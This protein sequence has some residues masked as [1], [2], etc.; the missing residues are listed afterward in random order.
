MTRTLPTSYTETFLELLEV[1]ASSSRAP[2]NLSVFWPDCGDRYT[3]ELLVVGRAANTWYRP[4]AL[5]EDCLRDFVDGWNTSG[6]KR[7]SS[8]GFWRTVRAIAQR[9]GL[10]SGPE[11]VLS[12]C[13]TNLFKVG[14]KEDNPSRSFRTV[15]TSSSIK[16]LREEIA[17]FNPHRVLVISG[18]DWFDEFAKGLDLSGPKLTDTYV[19][20]VIEDGQ[21]RWVVADRPDS[22]RKGLTEADWVDHVLAAFST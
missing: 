8:S 14:P 22:R 10:G 1:V 2:D 17:I 4:V 16:L 21:R 13:Y 19:S 15:G 6:F 18:Q 9:L 5:E 11:S 7:S 12:C 20:S 3:G